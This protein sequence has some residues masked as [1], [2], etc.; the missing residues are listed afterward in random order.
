[1]IELWFITLIEVIVQS[2]LWVRPLE[3]SRRVRPLDGAIWSKQQEEQLQHEKAGDCY[4][5]F[6]TVETT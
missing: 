6:F 1:M 4:E 5:K 3:R 2:V